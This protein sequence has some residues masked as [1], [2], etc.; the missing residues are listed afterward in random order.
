MR[1]YIVFWGLIIA[2]AIVV[3]LLWK[4]RNKD[5]EI[6]R[7]SWQDVANNHIEDPPQKKS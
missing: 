1:I 2:A 6:F 4:K 3:F 5:A 7:K